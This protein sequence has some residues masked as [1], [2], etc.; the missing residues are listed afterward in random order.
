MQ[1][2]KSNY[3][4]VKIGYIQ[5]KYRLNFTKAENKNQ[6]LADRIFQPKILVF[7]MYR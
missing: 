5:V 4:S 6:Y 1:I 3:V 7:K 2:I